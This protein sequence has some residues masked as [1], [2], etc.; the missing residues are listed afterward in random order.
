MTTRAP[1]ALAS[2]PWK[3]D[4]LA[5]VNDVAVRPRP[6]LSAIA[7]LSGF[8]GRARLPDHAALSR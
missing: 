7:P 3:P 4:T 1:F 2:G 8:D 6:V 5:S